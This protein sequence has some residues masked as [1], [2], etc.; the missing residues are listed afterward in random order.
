MADSIV[1]Y[2]E[3]EEA[4]SLIQELDAAGLNMNYTGPMPVQVE[5]ISSS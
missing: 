5:S 3:N 2:F 1:S 4:I